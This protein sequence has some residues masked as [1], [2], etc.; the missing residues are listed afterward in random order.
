MN[1]NNILIAIMAYGILTAGYTQRYENPKILIA[2][3]NKSENNIDIEDIMKRLCLSDSIIEYYNNLS[4]QISNKKLFLREHFIRADIFKRNLD[5]QPDTEYISQVIFKYGSDSD[6]TSY[7]FYFIVIHGSNEKEYTPYW[8]HVFENY[9]CNLL[10]SGKTVFEFLNDKK[11]GY[12]II[13]FRRNIV[14]SCGIEL[15]SHDQVD[16]LFYSNGNYFFHEGLPFNHYYSN[17]M[18]LT[19]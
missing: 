15:A 16:T 6:N 2:R 10:T 9:Q 14:E 13:L 7:K 18:D 8:S 1:Y 17:R 3:M 11:R 19:E 4:L 5:L 12:S